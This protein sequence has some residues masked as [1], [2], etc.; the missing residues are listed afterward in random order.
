[1]KRCLNA[2][3]GGKQKDLSGHFGVVS[4]NTLQIFKQLP[5]QIR[6]EILIYLGMA[7]SP[8]SV[9]FAGKEHDYYNDGW[10]MS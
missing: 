7:V 10:T 5:Y 1:M 8:W 3:P 2:L 4:L 9:Y 6:L